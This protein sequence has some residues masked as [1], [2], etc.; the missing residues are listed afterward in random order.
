MCADISH[1]VSFWS[2]VPRR[3]FVKVPCLITV[4][5]SQRVQWSQYKMASFS[6]SAYGWG[7]TRENFLDL[8]SIIWHDR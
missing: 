6:V 4:D 1:H 7:D 8:E 2:Q 5:V 3:H